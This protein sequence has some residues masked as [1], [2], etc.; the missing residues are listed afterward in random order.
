MRYL[1]AGVIVLIIATGCQ[2]LPSGVKETGKATG[3]T[4]S[5]PTTKSANAPSLTQGQAVNIVLALPLVKARNA[6][7]EM[8]S[9]GKVHGATMPQSDR[10][11]EMEGRSRWLIAFGESHPERFL[12]LQR[13]AVD[14]ATG[15]AQVVDDETQKLRSL[16]QWCEDKYERLVTQ[17]YE[18]TIFDFCEEGC[19]SC[20]KQIYYG[21]SRKTGKSILLTGRTLH[22]QGKDGT[23]GMFHGYEFKNGDTT[24]QVLEEGNG[25]ALL[26]VFRN[27]KNESTI[28]EESGK[29]QG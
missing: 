19:V 11:E 22:S 16:S 2:K 3:P 13:F 28:V 9:K 14:A 24:Y 1:A 6:Y 8:Q 17:N 26:R 29:W 5:Q 21:E 23:P 15:E 20:D 4:S 25:S 12:T 18:V 7:I 10:P 27:D